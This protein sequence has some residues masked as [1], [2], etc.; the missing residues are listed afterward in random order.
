MRNLVINSEKN[1]QIENIKFSANTL[2]LLKVRERENGKGE[3]DNFVNY[4]EICELQDTKEITIIQ[5]LLK[6]CFAEYKTAKGFESTFKE[7]NITQ[8][9][10]IKPFLNTNVIFRTDSNGKISKALISEINFN[11]T[12]L[13]VRETH[14]LTSCKPENLKAAM[15][16]HS[17]AVL[18]QCTYLSAINKNVLAIIQACSAEGAKITKGEQSTLTTETKAKAA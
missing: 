17:K 8:R 5:N 4:L 16:N 2:V 11:K 3:I 13:N 12:A 10:I 6:Y 15:Y 9:Q 14:T 1:V 18:A 7:T